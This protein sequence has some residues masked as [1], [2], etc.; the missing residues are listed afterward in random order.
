MDK[1]TAGSVI[2]REVIRYGRIGRAACIASVCVTSAMAAAPAL[3]QHAVRHPR[4][5][6]F[7]VAPPVPED[8][9]IEA[10]DVESLPSAGREDVYTHALLPVDMP[11]CT[12]SSWSTAVAE[13]KNRSTDLNIALGGVLAAEG[14]V[15]SALAAILPS[16]SANGSAGISGATGSPVS[17]IWSASVSGSQSIVDLSSWRSI[18]AAETQANVSRLSADDTRRTLAL[19]LA[20]TLFGVLTAHRISDINREGLS[21]AVERLRLSERRTELGGG[22]ALDVVR[23]RQDVE[24]ALATLVEGDEALR[25]A[26]EALGLALGHPEAC[27]VA[28]DVHV[29]SISS[30]ADTCHVVELDERAD[31]A[32]LHAAMVAAEQRKEAVTLGYL[33]TLG[34]T[35][36]AGRSIYG[37]NIGVNSWSIQGVLTVPI[38]DGGNRSG[39]TRSAEGQRYIAEEQL[40]AARRHALVEVTQ[41]RRAVEA[42]TA[43]LDA[44]RAARDDAREVERLARSSFQQ[45]LTASLDLITAAEQL[46]AAETDFAIRELQLTSARMLAVLTVARCS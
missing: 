25:R 28:T 17:G 13:A 34:V 8:A 5:A 6:R 11:T 41:A 19:S 36:F 14:S 20:N 7:T 3:A 15:R 26:R 43:A 1:I 24:Q 18:R 9:P 44:S 12:V 2:L 16:F 38:W 33:P 45:G 31:L 21:Q 27:D 35:A 30:L 42:A 32:A 23:A 37:G 40:E 39:A 29:D 4:P 46:R 10:V 22:N